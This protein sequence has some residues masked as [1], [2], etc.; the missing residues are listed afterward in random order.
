MKPKT[1]KILT[2]IWKVFKFI[3]T[4]GISHEDKYLKKDNK[5]NSNNQGD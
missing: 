1:L 2:L 4:L 5:T 3:V